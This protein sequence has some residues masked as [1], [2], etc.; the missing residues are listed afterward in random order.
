M[1]KVAPKESHSS[2]WFDEDA[3]NDPNDVD[4]GANN[5]SKVIRLAAVRRAISNFVSILSGKNVPV[6]FEGE[7][8]LTNGTEVIIAADDNPKNFDVTVGLALHEAAHVLLSN[9]RWLN[10]LSHISDRVSWQDTFQV[11]YDNG[12]GKVVRLS[13]HGG[14]VGEVIF[15]PEINEAIEKNIEPLIAERIQDVTDPYQVERVKT[16]TYGS[17]F[18]TYLQNMLLICNVLEDRR[19]DKFVYGTAQGYRPYYNALYDKYFYTNEASK[20]IRLDPD[21]RIPKVDNYIN[22]MIHH[23]H[24][25]SDP[26][27]LPGLRDIF[28]TMDLQ[29]IERIAPENDVVVEDMVTYET[30]PKIWQVANDIMA[31]IVKHV[32]LYESMKPSENKGE[33]EDDSES[34][35]TESK[36]TNDEDETSPSNC[37]GDGNGGGGMVGD[38][39]PAGGDTGG[40]GAGISQPQE[41]RTKWEENYTRN[42]KIEKQIQQARDVLMGNVKKKK[43]TKAVAK[44]VRALEQAQGEMVSIPVAGLE[45]VSCMVTRNI[46]EELMKED[47]FLF[48]YGYV[49]PAKADAIAAGRRMG[50]ILHQRLQVRND[51]IVTRQTRLS[52][53]KIERRLLANLGMDNTDVFYRSRTDKHKP[54]MLHLTIDGS[55]SMSGS[56]FNKTLT[57]ATAFAFL[58][59]KMDNVDVVISLRGGTDFPLVSVVY[60]S[61]RDA[62]MK[63]MK[64]APYL[65]AGGN[66]PEGLCFAAT[67]DLILESKN[68]HDVYFI[69]F[70]DGMPGFLVGEGATIT[71][72]P[73][74]TTTTWYQGD[75]AVTHTR[76]MVRH[77]RENGV[78]ILS[79]FIESSGWGWGNNP[80]G[81]IE[82]NFRK[83]YGD[84]DAVFV[85]VS[86]VTQ[87][88]NT[89][90]KRLKAM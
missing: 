90:N 66:T 54:A 16:N 34:P 40:T 24:P 5:I 56:K 23:I 81:A 35:F 39:S 55:G 30:T 13:T 51:P 60:D 6:H 14:R 11:E 44:S 8:S 69:N 89:M 10:T 46:T 61:R 41:P 36:S 50:Q 3:W 49:D 18:K 12:H 67:M 29:N 62:F 27:A 15:R 22:H 25:D 84:E 77:L 45:N 33:D 63:W 83:M 88:I 73:Q 21:A 43:I 68:T 58:S 19:I 2:Y 65:S 26:D 59:S 80:D 20:F 71:K 82:R 79:Y 47:W 31:I 42:N 76:K 78:K 74:R 86:N 28:R 64:F 52:S 9:F 7:D 37:S 87:V 70:S 53:G 38:N 4:T 72:G 75:L 32:E 17:V 57:V 85:D 48:S 1:P